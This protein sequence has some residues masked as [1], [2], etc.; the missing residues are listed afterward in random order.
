[1]FERPAHGGSRQFK[2]QLSAPHHVFGMQ[3]RRIERR[4]K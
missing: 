3:A 1:M 2:G 4:N